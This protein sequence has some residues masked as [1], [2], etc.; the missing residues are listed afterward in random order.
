MQ[1]TSKRH[2]HI[3]RATTATQYIDLTHNIRNISQ[4]VVDDAQ[5]QRELCSTMVEYTEQQSDVLKQFKV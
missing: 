3:V 5:A 4:S 1:A 2:K